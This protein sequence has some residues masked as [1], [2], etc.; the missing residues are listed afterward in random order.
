MA[1][2]LF[3]ALLKYWRG[4]RGLSQLDL[5]LHAGVSS[6]HVSFLESGRAQPSEAMVRRLFGALDVP[7]ADRDE[8]LR[9][10][11][12]AVAEPK[13]DAPFAAPI[14]DAITRILEAQEPYPAIVVTLE[15]RVLRHNRAASTLFADFVADPTKL[16]SPIDMFALVF[17]PALQRPFIT[18]WEAV[19]RQM[20][21]RLQREALHRRGERLHELTERVLRYPD[22]PSAW[23]TP[24]FAEAVEP[25]F[26]IRLAKGDVRLGFLTTITTFSAPQ[27]APLEELRI[28]CCF[29][30]DEATRRYCEAR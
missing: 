19:A 3:S 26:T 7:L 20:L 1:P 21:A 12:F 6:R 22:V 17:D 8:A 23:R 27:S 5:A 9:A 15:A 28:E 25:T 18:N 30:L 4:R 14:E 24:D 13:K 29:P 11:G 2:G 16:V 10:A